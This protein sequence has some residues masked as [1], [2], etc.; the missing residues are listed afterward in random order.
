MDLN[1]LSIL[2]KGLVKGVSEAVIWVMTLLWNAS[3]TLLELAFRISDT[4]ASPDLSQ[5]GPLRSILGTTLWLS[6]SLATLLAL[7]QLTVALVRRDG[8]SLGRIFLG[9]V[10]YALVWGSF[11][12]VW[13]ALV[14]SASSLQKAI[15]QQTLHADGLAGFTTEV[16]WPRDITDAT[17]ATILAVTSVFL[18]I[19]ATFMIITMAVFRGAALIVLAAVTPITAAGLLAQVGAPIFAKQARWGL[20][21][22]LMAPTEALVLGVGV[23]V[24]NADIAGAGSSTPKAIGTGIIAAGVVVVAAV[25]PLALFRL[26]AWV[27]PGTPSGAALRQAWGSASG[28]ILGNPVAGAGG[29]GGGEGSQNASSLGKAA[30]GAAV[31]GPTGAATAVAGDGRSGGEHQADSATQSR[32]TSALGSFGAGVKNVAGAGMRMADL[33]ADIYGGAGIG[34]PGYSMSPADQAATSTDTGT[35]RRR[36]PPQQAQT[37][38]SQPRPPAPNT[39]GSTSPTPAP[40]GPVSPQPG[41]AP[42]PGAPGAGGQNS[43]PGSGAQPGSRGSGQKGSGK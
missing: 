12:S 38:P 7:V 2:G 42:R 22:V 35:P 36:T 5:E 27:D 32:I 31:G 3:L 17:L 9:I 18:I 41:G 4:F 37:A 11:T 43:A 15:L 16:S 19:P 33:S 39:G 13:A 23:Q 40:G 8:Q 28:R 30:A 14:V 21:A 6:A 25:S 26:L 20:A 34:S 1:P 29:G 24:A 10:Q